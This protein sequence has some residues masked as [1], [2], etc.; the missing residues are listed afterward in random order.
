MNT[1]LNSLE[2]IDRLVD[3]LISQNRELLAKNAK[4]LADKSELVDSYNKL[5]TYYKL[6]IEQLKEQNYAL[7]RE[8]C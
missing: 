7:L 5:D 6:T 3:Q 2:K 8:I 1:T 4:L